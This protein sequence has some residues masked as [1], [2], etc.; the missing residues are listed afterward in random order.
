[1]TRT[2]TVVVVPARRASSR[3][4]EKLL[5]AES[6][7]PL[8]AHTL[9]Q[10]LQAKQV[11]AVI[12]A[13]DCPELAAVA[14]EAGAEVLLTDPAL[15]SGS[16][17]VWAAIHKDPTIQ[18]VIN[19][20]GDEPEID[21]A[22]IDR[23]A[24]ALKGGAAVATLSA[25]LSADAWM[26]PAA[27]K[28][29]AGSDGQATSFFRESPTGKPSGEGCATARLHIGIYGYQRTVLEQFA[30]TPPCKEEL[31]ARLEQL[32]LF[33]MGIPIQV[34]NWPTAFA[35]I[36]TRLDYDRFLKRLESPAPPSP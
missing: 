26:D 9:H 18:A 31:E 23:I 16:D 22:A 10:C 29:E 33:S 2:S 1:M 3:L 35:G 7:R 30:K 8:L 15:A 17:R 21:P 5:L 20:Q 13:V 32:R 24:D 12:A 4:P 34:L 36:D 25:P 6:G 28:V 14:Q 11:R 27:V 19:V